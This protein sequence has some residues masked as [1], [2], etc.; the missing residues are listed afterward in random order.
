MICPHCS[1]YNSDNSNFCSCC[2]KPLVNS[3][4]REPL[5]FSFNRAPERSNEK[6]VACFVLSIVGIFFAGL[7]L[8]ILSIVFYGLAK[9]EFN[10]Y[11]DLSGRSLAKAG[12]IIAIVMCSLYAILFLYFIVIFAI[13]LATL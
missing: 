5:N 9:K 1:S 2:G 10:L 7:I 6:A 11:P 12:F 4:Y 3:T 13:L 8:E